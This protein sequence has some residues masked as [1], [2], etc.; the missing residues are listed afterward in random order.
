MHHPEVT[1]QEFRYQRQVMTAGSHRVPLVGVRAHQHA[2]RARLVEEP[3]D[4][5]DPIDPAPVDPV[6]P[7]EPVL[8]SQPIASPLPHEPAVQNAASQQNPSTQNIASTQP[9][10]QAGTSPAVP[11]SIDAGL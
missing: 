1:H 9:A 10:T 4:P 8:P 3:T 11:L 7:V 5:I 2:G 6:T